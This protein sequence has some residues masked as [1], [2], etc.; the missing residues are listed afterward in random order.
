MWTVQVVLSTFV[1][2]QTVNLP[3]LFMGATISILPL[4]LVFIFMQSYLVEGVRLTG[5]KG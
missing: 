2:A 3:G 1:T 4:L 5:V